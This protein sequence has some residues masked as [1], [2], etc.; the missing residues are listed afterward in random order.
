MLLPQTSQLCWLM[1]ACLSTSTSTTLQKFPTPPPCPFLH[2][3]T[4]ADLYH[5]LPSTRQA[6]R[7]RVPSYPISLGR[8][9]ARQTVF[10]PPRLARSLARSNRTLTSR[11]DSPRETSMGY[12]AQCTT[13]VGRSPRR[14]SRFQHPSPLSATQ[15]MRSKSLCREALE[16]NCP[17]T[18]DTELRSY[19]TM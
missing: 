11:E 6:G 5:S 15:H 9:I 1:C 19:H 12:H 3:Q 14:L 13:G 7:R 17:S 18:N 8:A 2:P 16:K 4:P 10:A